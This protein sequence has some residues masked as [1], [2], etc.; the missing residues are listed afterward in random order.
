MV[1]AAE[2]TTKAAAGNGGDKPADQ[3]TDATSAAPPV[4]Q[5]YP[6]DLEEISVGHL[7]LAPEDA[8]CGWLEAIV[9]ARDD[10]VL[11]LR[12]RDYPRLPKFTHHRTNVALLK[13]QAA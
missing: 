9:I 12:W 6:R 3:A 5:G 10:D 11:K 1:E 13:H 4:A 2:A 8:N 7:V